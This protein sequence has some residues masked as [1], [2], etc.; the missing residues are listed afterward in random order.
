M[1]A[2]N[3]SVPYQVCV[4]YLSLNG[5]DASKSLGRSIQLADVPSYLWS[6]VTIWRLLVAL[7]V[8]GNLKNIPLMWHV[9]IQ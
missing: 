3:N 5:S 2:L 9:S 4:P 7:L 1:A 8:L 6:F